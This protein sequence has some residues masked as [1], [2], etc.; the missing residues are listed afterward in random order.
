MASRA[1]PLRCGATRGSFARRMAVIR[2]GATLKHIAECIALTSFASATLT[3]G[4]IVRR[5][6]IVAGPTRPKE[7]ALYLQARLQCCMGVIGCAAA[8]FGE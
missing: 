3:S 5:A 6:A 7:F 2:E 8:D 1:V 4:L